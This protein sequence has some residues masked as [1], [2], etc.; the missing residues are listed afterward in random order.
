M[1][2]QQLELLIKKT[3]D[4]PSMPEIAFEVIRVVDA[5]ESSAINVAQ[6]LAKDPSLSARV[7]RL[8]NSAFYGLSRKVTS[9]SDAVVVLGMRTVKSLALVAASFPWLQRALKGKGL[10]PD[11]LW[12]H[13]FT[14]ALTAKEIALASGKVDPEFAFCTGLLHDMGTVVLCLWKDGDF[15]DFSKAAKQTEASFDT[16]ER[17]VLGFDHAE[18]GAALASQWNLPVEYCSAIKFHHR[19]SESDNPDLLTDVIHIADC[20]V[21]EAGITEGIEG[22]VYSRDLAAF[23][24]LGL[25]EEQLT[26]AFEKALEESKSEFNQEKVA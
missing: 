10:S 11:L 14:V 19:P 24:R 7:L 25:D 5:A 12:N 3:S 1:S 6:Q 26:I 4:L 13:C 18:V 2:A 17:S 9:I 16:V 21:R 8:A 15:K 23:E 22:A 20:L